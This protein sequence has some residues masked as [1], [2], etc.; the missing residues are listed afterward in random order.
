M[1]KHKVPTVKKIVKSM[2]TFSGKMSLPSESLGFFFLH[3]LRNDDGDFV[4]KDG[5]RAIAEDFTLLKVQP[6]SE[7]EYCATAKFDPGSNL[8][9]VYESNCN[10]GN[11]TV[12]RMLKNQNQDCA[13]PFVKKVFY[14][15]Q[16]LNYS[17]SSAS[18]YMDK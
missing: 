12:C 2:K 10:T 14:E 13:V 11:G 4:F 6:D 7:T 1:K 18:F 3:A 8:L 16:S 15:F 9:N 5:T 17:E